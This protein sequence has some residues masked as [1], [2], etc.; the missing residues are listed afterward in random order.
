[1]GP[2]LFRLDKPASVTLRFDQLLAGHKKGKRCLT[3]VRKGR[4]CTVVRLAGGMSLAQ[5]D[6]HAGSNTVKF[7]GRIGKRALKPG[8][9]RLTATP[10][11]G[12]G[13]TVRFVVVKAP[14]R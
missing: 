14:K 10:L 8:R 7:S 5:R 4:R 11:R 3:K 2:V 13:R 6:L 1:M 9:Y 12:T